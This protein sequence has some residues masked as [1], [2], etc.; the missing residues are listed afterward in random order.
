[1]F[2][3]NNGES[4]IWILIVSKVFFVISRCIIGW[5]ICVFCYGIFFVMR[6][7]KEDYNFWM[8]WLLLVMFVLKRGGKEFVVLILLVEGWWVCFIESYWE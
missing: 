1:M 8:S 6:V 2:Y 5:L 4:W 3:Y 7:E